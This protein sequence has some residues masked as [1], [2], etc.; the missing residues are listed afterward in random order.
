MRGL[1]TMHEL[2][3]TQSIVDIVSEK[4]LSRQ[5]IRVKLAI[6][7]LSAIEPDAVQ[8][9]FDVC[10]KG[11]YAEGAALEIDHIEG[12]GRC[13]NCA[14][15]IPLTQSSWRCQCGSNDI[16]CIAGQELT[17]TELEVV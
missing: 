9:C 6:G 15:E 3:I 8:F 7:K 12:L 2:A 11:T 4:A 5:V 14:T 17:I 13:K 10:T 16:E 1:G